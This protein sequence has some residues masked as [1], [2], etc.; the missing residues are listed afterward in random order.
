M[1]KKDMDDKEENA[2]NENASF[3]GVNKRIIA[4]IKGV[5]FKYAQ[6]GSSLSCLNNVSLQVR[7]GECVLL[8]GLS[9]CGKTTITRLINGLIPHYYEGVMSGS[10]EL[11]DADE[12]TFD[13]SDMGGLADFDSAD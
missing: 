7:E 10:V 4:E 5:S 11:E 2:L 9:G 1:A 3:D 12:F 8:T 13:D 6:D